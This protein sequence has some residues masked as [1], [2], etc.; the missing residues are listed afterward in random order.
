MKRTIYHFNS[1]DTYKGRAINALL[2]FLTANRYSVIF[3]LKCTIVKRNYN[4]NRMKQRVIDN[5]IIATIF[6]PLMAALTT[7][8]NQCGHYQITPEK[9]DNDSIVCAPS[10]SLRSSIAHPHTHLKP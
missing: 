1:S 8:M 4:P 5:I 7:I 9:T 6:I 3:S 10:D 2:A